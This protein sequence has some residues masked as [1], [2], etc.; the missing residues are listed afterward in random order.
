VEGCADIR[1]PFGEENSADKADGARKRRSI[2]SDASGSSEVVVKNAGAK[3]TALSED[4]L[5]SA[6]D[7]VKIRGYKLRKTESWGLD[8]VR[9]GSVVKA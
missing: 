5:A 2:S 4:E 1:L 6:S 9:R 3:L 7:A 8:E